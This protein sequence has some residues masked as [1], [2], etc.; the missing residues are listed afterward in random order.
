MK[1]SF[2]NLLYSDNIRAEIQKEEILKIIEAQNK[3]KKIINNKEMKFK[4]KNN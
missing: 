4:S 3:K 2:I 1:N